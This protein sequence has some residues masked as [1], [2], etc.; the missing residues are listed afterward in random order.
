MKTL[1][2]RILFQLLKIPIATKFVDHKKMK[3][4]LGLQYPLK[5]FQ[6]YI[7]TRNLHILQMM[8]EGIARSEEYWIAVG[9]RIELGRMLT[10]AKRN[11][12]AAE[13]ERRKRKNED[14]KNK[15][16]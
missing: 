6:D 11:F 5:D 12:E 2:I 1:L 14:S 4:W 9:Q 7:A 10:E 13:A 16:G 3:D 8:G 15:K